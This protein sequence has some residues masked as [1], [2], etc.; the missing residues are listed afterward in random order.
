MAVCAL[1]LQLH[2]GCP[3]GMAGSGLVKNFGSEGWDG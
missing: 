1:G 2:P 3:L